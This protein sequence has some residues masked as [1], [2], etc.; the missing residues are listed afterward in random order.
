VFSKD[1]YSI[2]GVMPSAED[3]VIRAAYKAL[4][5]RYHPDKYK[6]DRAEAER[7]M[8]EINEAYDTLSDPANRRQYDD[9]YK[10]QRKN[11]Y[12][13]EEDDELADAMHAFNK[14]WD[15]A[16]NI[17]P[18]L[19][20]IVERLGRVATRLAITYKLLM[21]EGKEFERRKYIA[22]VM[23]ADF[24]KAYF[25]K[26]PD[27]I[28]FA[29]KLVYEGHKKAAKALNRYIRVV[30]M[31]ADS[32]LIIDKIS[33]EY[34]ISDADV[35]EEVADRSDIRG[36]SQSKA[37]SNSAL[38][39]W[40]AVQHYYIAALVPP[41]FARMDLGKYVMIMW[42][43]YA[44]FFI[45]PLFVYVSCEMT[46]IIWGNSNF[47]IA[48]VIGYYVF[49]MILGFF[50]AFKLLELLPSH[51]KYMQQARLDKYLTVFERRFTSKS[52]SI[53]AAWLF[54][55]PWYGYYGIIWPIAS[56][57]TANFAFDSLIM[58]YV[59][60]D[61]NVSPELLQSYNDI[62]HAAIGI[63]S[64]VLGMVFHKMLFN[65]VKSRVDPYIADNRFV[66]AEIYNKCR[67]NS[68]RALM[69]TI[70]FFI[71]LLL[72][73]IIFPEAYEKYESALSAR[74]KAPKQLYDQAVATL[75]GQDT[76]LG[77]ITALTYAH[78]AAESGYTPAQSYLGFLY[79]DGKVMPKNVSI[80]TDW[81][82]KAARGGDAYA[83]SQLGYYLFEGKDGVVKD[84]KRAVELWSLAARK[85]E[86]N[87]QV[88]LGLAFI[89]GDGGLTQ[90]HTQ[91]FNWMARAAK[92]G[93]PDA[94][95][96]LGTFYEDGLAVKQDM[97]MALAYY[98]E[99]ARRGNKYAVDRLAELGIQQH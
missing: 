32:R 54:P 76:G 92:Q 96:F 40:Q 18:D 57:A 22:N 95:F 55:V 17:Y 62:S 27:I 85:D 26:D 70:V 80:M 25:G 56:L 9:W 81:F 59:A 82:E 49:A 44:V 65:S 20:E 73:A 36:T 60:Q 84:Q 34:G 93:H 24:F 14:D 28:R 91:A 94:Y 35:A 75:S 72:P 98:K 67:P 87:A 63:A 33:T 21:L 45:I 51:K 2:L 13:T 86:M 47:A 68:W 74:G 53:S 88:N 48:D 6:G 5:Q 58:I 1:Y 3:I 8:K 66:A 31:N 64:I 19:R 77:T 11:E 41:D 16:C 46:R 4:A 38:T 78:I 30:G 10:A 99:G 71:A 89:R 7:L 69:A 50:C 15:I 90:S 29:R 23:E 12:Q 43:R 42:L 39:P 79:E 37:K 61:Y 97:G 83:A 52:S